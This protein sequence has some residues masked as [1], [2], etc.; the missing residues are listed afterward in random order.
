VQLV[1]LSG[2]LTCTSSE[3]EFQKA[4]H[5]VKELQKKGLE[6]VLIPGNHDHYTKKDYANKVFYRFFPIQY[7]NSLWN[8][9]DH[10]IAVKHLQGAWWMILLDT[11]LAT[12][13]FSC[14]G[15]FSQ[16]LEKKLQEVLSFLPK[17]ARILLAN[18][19]PLQ[20]S[21]KRPDLQGEEKLVEILKKDPRIK[22]YLHGHNHKN[23][24]LDLRQQGLPIVAD[25][26]SATHK[27]QGSFLILDC[28]DQGLSISPFFWNV[29]RN[30]WIKQKTKNSFIW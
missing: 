5:F 3:K 15:K 10:R 7:E 20:T 26:G 4:R 9:K 1:L 21:K 27:M 8:L 29:N 2:D 17:D 23:T 22:C 24:I 28:Q 6:V 14:R 30:S 19:F 25:A 13:L 18:H 16:A 12:P 11:T